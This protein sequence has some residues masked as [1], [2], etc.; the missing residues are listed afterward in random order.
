MKKEALKKL[1]IRINL[2]KN[3]FK[4]KSL[5]LPGLQAQKETKTLHPL[6]IAKRS[7]RESTPL[8][9]KTL[10]PN[11]PTAGLILTAH[12]VIVNKLTHCLLIRANL[13]IFQAPRT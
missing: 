8:L 13:K 1:S 4:D 9:V 6:K 7:L 12:K 10:C 2:I 3:K 11:L 5:L